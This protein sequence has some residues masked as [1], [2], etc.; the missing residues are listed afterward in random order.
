VSDL[1]AEILSAMNEKL[2]EIAKAIYGEDLVLRLVN[3]KSIV[4]LKKNARYMSKTTFDQ[5]TANL[6]TDASLQSVPLCHTLPDG[7]LECLSGNHRVQAAIRAGVTEA[8]V[9][10]IPYELSK[11]KKISRQLSHNA[12][13]GQDD[14]TTLAELWS[15]IDDLNEKL[16]AGLD[17]D[18]IGE[19]EKINFEG[20]AA[21]AIRTE[22]VMFWFLPEEVARLDEVLKV[23][24][25]LAP[26]NPI[27][28]APLDR[29]GKMWHALVN[30]K[31]NADI[32]NTAVAFMMLI[33]AMAETEIAGDAAQ[34]VAFT[35]EQWLIVKGAMAKVRE[36]DDGPASAK[37]G[38][39]LELICAD[40]LSGADLSGGHMGGTGGTSPVESFDPTPP[41]QPEPEPVKAPKQKAGWFKGKKVKP[42][43][44]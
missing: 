36:A 27:Y 5:L 6:R 28:M 8:L 15:E 42:V 40:Y 2:A 26:G 12:L 23:Q 7:R 34:A 29:Y 24:E 10:V 1:S 13:V 31:K 3:P 14:L 4:L 11:A 43:K 16:Y 32:K 19:L 38:R 25:D 37:D 21:D 18:L 22:S 20:F 44:K 17:S 30:A 33:D 39:I 41:L 35:S 9:M